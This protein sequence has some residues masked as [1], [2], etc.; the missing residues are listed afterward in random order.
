M[1]SLL[2]VVGTCVFRWTILSD[3]LFDLLRVILSILV[4]LSLV[5]VFGLCLVRVTVVLLCLFILALICRVL[6]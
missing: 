5:V 1:L 4:L 6:L 2:C 3:R